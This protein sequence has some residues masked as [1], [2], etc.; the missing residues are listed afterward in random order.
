MEI[1]EKQYVKMVCRE[2]LKIDRELE[3][4]ARKKLELELEI[5]R[6]KEAQKWLQNSNICILKVES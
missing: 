2:I 4:L 3:R 1:G 6:I 5:I